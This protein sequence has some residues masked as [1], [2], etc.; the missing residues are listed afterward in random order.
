MD[1]KEKMNNTENESKENTEPA[2]P[3]F[4]GAMTPSKIGGK[5]SKAVEHE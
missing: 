5:F 2:I 3:F 1:E 4:V